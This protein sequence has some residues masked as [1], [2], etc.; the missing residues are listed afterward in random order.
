M[1]VI[2]CTVD[3][4]IETLGCD[5]CLLSI[6]GTVALNHQKQDPNTSNQTRFNKTNT[7]TKTPCVLICQIVV[8]CLTFFLMQY[9]DAINVFMLLQCLFG[10]NC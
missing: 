1:V 2:Y 6:I 8:C 7:N 4:N 10:G 5:L 9:I 3:I